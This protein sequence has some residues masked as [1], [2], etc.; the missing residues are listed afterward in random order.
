[1][2]RERE[3]ERERSE[4]FKE[5]EGSEAKERIFFRWIEKTSTKLKEK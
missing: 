4:K 1:M 2:R 3:R 5:K